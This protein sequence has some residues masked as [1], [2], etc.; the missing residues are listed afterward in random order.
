MCN[1]RDNNGHIRAEIAYVVV[2]LLRSVVEA[3]TARSAAPG[4][5]AS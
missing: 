4:I 5:G 1:D 2:S 3:G